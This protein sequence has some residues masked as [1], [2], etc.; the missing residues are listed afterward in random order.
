MTVI[1]VKKYPRVEKVIWLLSDEEVL[2]GGFEI[3][4]EIIYGYDEETG[5]KIATVI[6]KKKTDKAEG[7]ER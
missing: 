4:N 2:S 7:G 5:E 3:E 6:F 1:K